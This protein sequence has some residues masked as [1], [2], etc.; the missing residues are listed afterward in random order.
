MM[1][2]LPKPLPRPALPRPPV[3]GDSMTVCPVGDTVRVDMQGSVQNGYCVAM[4][5]RQQAYALG[6]ELLRLTK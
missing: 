6:I 2:P 4:L 5:T 1:P 3:F